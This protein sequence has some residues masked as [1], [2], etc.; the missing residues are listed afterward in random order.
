LVNISVDAQRLSVSANTNIQVTDNPQSRWN[1]RRLRCHRV[2]TPA[3]NARFKSRE[4]ELQNGW[5]SGPTQMCTSNC[6][7][8]SRLALNLNF[9][10]FN[11]S[12]SASSTI[13]LSGLRLD[14]PLSP[15]QLALCDQHLIAIAVW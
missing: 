7:V 2:A 14:E 11:R 4:T 8:R 15:Q 12:H 6:S 9:G 3:L 13:T 5:A 10:W 1:L